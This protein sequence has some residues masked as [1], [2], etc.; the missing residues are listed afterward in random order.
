MINTLAQMVVAP[1]MYNV[2]MD[3]DMDMDMVDMYMYMYM[4]M[5]LFVVVVC[6]TTCCGHVNPPKQ[7]QP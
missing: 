7:S 1:L 2:D 3:M 6:C 4:Y 5:L